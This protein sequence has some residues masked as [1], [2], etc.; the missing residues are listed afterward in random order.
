M[1]HQRLRPANGER[2]NDHCPAT[3]ES[4]VDDGFENVLRV[5]VRVYSVP[6]GRLDKYIV[7]FCDRGRI[8]HDRIIIPAKVTGKCDLVL[9]CIKQDRRCPE[10]MTRFYKCRTDTFPQ[11]DGV[12]KAVRAE[13]F[14]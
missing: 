7:R 14:E 8:V 4:A 2:W 9:A 12:A 5:R 10:N 3:L 1:E 13:V 11:R 6:I